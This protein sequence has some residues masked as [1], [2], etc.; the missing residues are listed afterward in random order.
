MEALLERALLAR[1][2]DV[3]A[4]CAVMQHFAQL[5]AATRP[6]VV[7]IDGLG[8]LLHHLLGGSSHHHRGVPKRLCNAISLCCSQKARLAP[9]ENI[10]SVTFFA[11]PVH[12]CGV[13]C[14]VM[15]HTVGAG[16]AELVAT[17]RY[18]K[19]IAR[20]CTAAVV[21][22][23]FTLAPTKQRDNFKPERQPLGVQWESM[24]HCRV[25]LSRL[26]AEDGRAR[27][28]QVRVMAT[29]LGA[30]EALAAEPVLV[31][32]AADGMRPNA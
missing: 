12:D 5:P 3:Y 28:R 8:S 24:P 30:E 9:V 7:L 11:S 21:C 25:L 15:R 10:A 31:L 17:G 18:L 1:A 23:T 26:H 32:L 27:P 20:Q 6:K 13:H 29:T 19:A 4:V 14:H 16:E 22:T 2:D